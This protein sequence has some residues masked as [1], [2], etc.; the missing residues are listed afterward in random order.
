MAIESGIPDL[1]KDGIIFLDSC[2]FGKDNP[3]PRDT[4]KE[5]YSI[6]YIKKETA[7][8][9]ALTTQLSSMDNWCIIK[10]VLEEFKDGNL[11]FNYRIESS[12][13]TQE[14]KAF[15]RL[16]RQRKETLRLLEQ[17]HVIEYFSLVI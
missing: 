7:R 5:K 8:L 13:V 9:E 10:E 14:K 11:T 2:A 1:P 16:L 6:N 4:K 12:R 15:E 3:A 17:E